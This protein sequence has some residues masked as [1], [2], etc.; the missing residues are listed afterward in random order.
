MMVEDG[1][2]ANI[3]YHIQGHQLHAV[4]F[5]TLAMSA[6][7]DV[8]E[9]TLFLLLRNLRAESHEAVRPQ[10]SC[11]LCSRQ[12]IVIITRVIVNA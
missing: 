1:A 5:F 12:Q 6:T 7:K 3:I 4:Y 2:T 11:R 10:S 9:G 8:K